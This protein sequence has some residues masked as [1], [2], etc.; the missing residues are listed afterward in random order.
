MTKSNIHSRAANVKPPSVGACL[1]SENRLCEADIRPD[2]WGLG[3]TWGGS[4]GGARAERRLHLAPLG[5]ELPGVGLAL[6]L[7]G[8]GVGDQAEAS[9]AT[10][11]L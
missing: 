1:D 3:S 5:R 10:E 6:G 4:A 9:E 11:E 7:A 2:G 8:A